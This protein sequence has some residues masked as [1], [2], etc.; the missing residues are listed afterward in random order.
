MMDRK[1]SMT[2]KGTNIDFGQLVISLFP[3][4][5]AIE[6]PKFGVLVFGTSG[7]SDL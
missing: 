5:L 2:C 6:F 1:G 7:I 3:P 4:Y